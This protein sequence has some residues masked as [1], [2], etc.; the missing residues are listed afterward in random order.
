MP[1]KEEVTLCN[2][3]EYNPNGVCNK[4][5]SECHGG[6]VENMRA[7]DGFLPKGLTEHEAREH[8]GRE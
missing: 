7:C 5:E 6:R 3:C 1:E 8:D 2:D 4:K